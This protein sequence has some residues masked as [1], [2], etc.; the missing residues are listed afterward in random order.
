MKDLPLGLVEYEKEKKLRKPSR[1]TKRWL[2]TLLYLIP[3][4]QTMNF[5]I[6]FYW[7]PPKKIIDVTAGNRLIWEKFPYNHKDLN[8]DQETWHVDFSDISP[9]AKTDIVCKAQDIDKHGHWDMLVCDFP[10][11]EM[12]KGMESFG[13]KSRKHQI[14]FRQNESDA[15]RREFYFREFRRPADLFKESLQSFNKATDSLI[16]KM[17]DSHEDRKM[18]NN[19]VDAI[20][21]FDQ[22][23]NPESEFHHIDTIHYRG[24]Y[25]KRGANVPFAQPVVS[26]YLI[27]KK[28]PNAR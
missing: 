4:N 10:F 15:M 22:R 20:L 14:R 23:R 28:D 5:I 13:T 11:I 3:L 9:Q 16:I 24:N 6:P 19:H 27:F 8:S 12:D 18:I 1:L 26:Y 17:G 2:T 7:N 25:S 21:T